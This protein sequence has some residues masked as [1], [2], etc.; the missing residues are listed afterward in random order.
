MPLKIKTHQVFGFFSLMSLLCLLLLLKRLPVYP[1]E[2]QWIYVNARQITDHTMQYLFPVCQQGF[3]IAQ[4][5]I[6]SPIRLLEWFFYSHL[7]F[8]HHIRMVGIIQAVVTIFLLNQFLHLYARKLRQSQAVLFSGL[9]IGL[10]PFLM[11]LNRPE[12]LLLI[13]FLSSLNLTHIY[14]RSVSMKKRAMSL[15]LIAFLIASMPAIHP[16]GSLFAVMGVAIFTFIVKR[17]ARIAKFAILGG[18]VLSIVVSTQIWSLRTLCPESKFLTSTFGD[19][20]LNPT[21]LN[22]S[23]ARKIIGNIIRTP[24]YLAN[25][26]YQNSYQSDWMAQR[27]EVPEL[28]L[29]L[30]NLGLCIFT[31]FLLFSIYKSI[32]E[33]SFRIRE[34]DDSRMIALVFL[35]GFA[36]LAVLQRT[37]NFYDSYLPAILILVSVAITINIDLKVKYLRPILVLPVII[38]IPALLMTSVNFPQENAA[39]N[40]IVARE[41]IKECGISQAQLKKGDFIIDGSL[42]GPLW[43]S[44]RFIYAV[45]LWGWW[46][47]DVDAERVM[48]NLKPPVIILQNVGL[49]P[50]KTGDVVV[51]QYMCRNLGKSAS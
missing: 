13:L 41:I 15:L 3:Q 50:R 2:E 27:N 5:V 51:G 38:T 10:L 37:K 20:T 44:P 42:S 7:G 16:K 30:A 9:L 35:T 23:T 28:I 18:A 24:K 32:R 40:E 22:S 48:K 47:Q 29:V 12:Q 26:M 19:I 1:D 33:E 6:W 43:G 25:M 45:Y 36:T 4:P 31:L 11:V 21:Q 14:N 46:A 17:K 49:I 34:L 39:N 8:V